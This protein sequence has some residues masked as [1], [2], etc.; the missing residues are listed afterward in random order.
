MTVIIHQP[1]TDV[2][3]VFVQAGIYN[4]DI[5]R[6]GY[7]KSDWYWNIVSRGRVVAVTHGYPKGAVKCGSVS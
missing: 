3:G 4:G 2:D 7:F 1:F 5:I 6:R